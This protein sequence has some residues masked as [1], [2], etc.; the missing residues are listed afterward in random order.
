MSYIFHPNLL[1]SKSKLM[2]HHLAHYQI[3]PLTNS[4]HHTL[5]S[6]II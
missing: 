2:G 3:F 6:L 5:V 4:C 1:K